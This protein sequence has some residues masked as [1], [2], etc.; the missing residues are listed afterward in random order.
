MSL[1]GM[2]RPAEARRF[3]GWK[4]MAVAV[5]S[6]PTLSSERRRLAGDPPAAVE[7]EH[8]EPT[9]ICYSSPRARLPGGSRS[10]VHTQVSAGVASPAALACHLCVSGSKSDLGI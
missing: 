10:S 8:H 7:I 2:L 1:A 4:F 5:A 3:K 6:A 9:R